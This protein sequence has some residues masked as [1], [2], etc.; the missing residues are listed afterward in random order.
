MTIIAPTCRC[1]PPMPIGTTCSKCGKA[2]TAPVVYRTP[3]H[4]KRREALAKIKLTE[5]QKRDRERARLRATR[6]R[7][8]PVPPCVSPDGVFERHRYLGHEACVR[9]GFSAIA[10]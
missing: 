10:A 5:T 6:E 1:D 3:D 4:E 8:A 2:L 9:C 7:K